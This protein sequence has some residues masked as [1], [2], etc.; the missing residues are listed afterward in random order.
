MIDDGLYDP[1]KHAVPHPDVVIG[2]H[3]MPMRAGT[4]STRSGAFN[5]TSESMRVTFYGRGGHGAKPHKTVDLVIMACSAVLKLQTI[6][7]REIDPQQMAVVTVGSIHAGNA[8]NVIPDEATLLIN[9]R[10]FST[11]LQEKVRDSI[12][13]IILAES[14]AFGAPTPPSVE[15]I[16]FFPLLYND[17]SATWVVEQSMRHHFGHSFLPGMAVSTGSEDISNL[18][19][20][21]LPL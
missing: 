12:G 4:I 16:T 3:A 9:V 7:S 11:S 20:P 1:L 14:E 13:R 8:P 6:V 15:R 19:T 5:S 2:G 21:Y 10:S 17:P 18:A